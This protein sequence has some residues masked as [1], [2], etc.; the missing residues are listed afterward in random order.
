MR[1]PTALLLLQLAATQ[2]Q[3]TETLFDALIPTECVNSELL[4]AG[5]CTVQN[6]CASICFGQDTSRSQAALFNLDSTGLANF[7]IPNEATSCDEFQ[8]P[9]CPAT[10][11]CPACKTELN[12]LYRCIIRKGNYE[13]ID[14][15]LT[16]YCTL[17]CRDWSHL[18]NNNGVVPTSPPTDVEIE[19][20]SN[21][22]DFNE[23]N[24]EIE[25]DSNFTD[26]NETDDEIEIDSNFTDFNETE[27]EDEEEEEDMEEEDL[28]GKEDTKTEDNVEAANQMI[29]DANDML[30]SAYAQIETANKMIAAANTRIKVANKMIQDANEMVQAASE[31]EDTSTSGTVSEQLVEDLFAMSP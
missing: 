3:T 19:T 24:V 30:E 25:T 2:S 29:E 8:D 20:N 28:S 7:Y 13:D 12:A 23:T 16:N 22:T 27:W 1:L 31:Q 9:I 14:E 5:F 17:D 10:N 18:G 26:F 21:S 15:T 6:S 4:K 11:C